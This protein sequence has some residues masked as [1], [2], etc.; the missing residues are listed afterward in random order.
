MSC[1]C[2]KF[3]FAGLIAAI[4]LS[5]VPSRAATPEEVDAAVLRGQTYLLSQ[6]K[7]GN[8][9][10]IPEPKLDPT[11]D[12]TWNNLQRWQWGGRTAAA[13]YGILASGV[14]SSDPRIAPTIE[15]LSNAH[16]QGFYAIS[17]R[18]QVWP[19]LPE[20][21]A[22]TA[23]ATDYKLLLNGMHPA[24]TKEGAKQ[25]FYPYF[26]MLPPASSKNAE[27]RAT[28]TRQPNWYDR[29][30]SQLCVL[31]MW[32]CEQAGQQVPPMYWRVVDEAWKKTQLPDGGWSYNHGSNVSTATMT[33][34]GVATLYIT[35]DYLLRNNRWE[36]CRG[37]V[38]DPF[39]DKG[40]AWIDQHIGEIVEAR[41]KYPFYAM[42]GLERI[43]VASGRKYFGTTDWY[44]VGAEYLVKNQQ[45][46]GSWGGEEELNGVP[47][48]VFAILYLVR[49][50]APVVMNKLEYQNSGKTAAGRLAQADPWNERP[51]DVANF[52]HWSGKQTEQYLN[53]QIVNLQV[54]SSELHDAPILYIAGSEA[55]ALSDDEVAKLRSFAEEGGLILGNADGG[56]D[57]FSRSF[58]ALGHKLFPKYEFRDLPSNHPI[59]VDEQYKASKWKTK[60]KIQGL[61]NGVRELM[62]L[63][64][65]SDVGRY[66]QTADEK[67]KSELFEL[68]QNILFYATDISNL[69]KRGDSYIVEMNPAAKV[70][71]TVQVAR[72]IV[73]DNPDPEPGGWR[74]LAAVL[75]NDDKIGISVNE[76][77]LGEGKLAGNK[78]AH[79]TGTTKFTLNDAQK[80]ELK[81]FVAA[82]GTLIVDAAG[83]SSAFEESADRELAAIFG[84]Q[85]SRFGTVLPATHEIYSVLNAKPQDKRGPLYR[86]FAVAKLGALNAPRVRGMEQGGRVRVFLSEEDLSA[87][88]VGEQV[89]GIVGYNP[90]SATDIMRGI[91]RYATGMKAP[92]PTTTAK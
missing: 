29:S 16:I 20:R 66:W 8:C 13:A 51:R 67:G 58:T 81:D 22:K 10:Y 33:A 9:E 69:R 87:G 19:F 82:G 34:A 6:I 32:S 37:G 65:K 78:I 46:G 90:T 70:S 73:G 23:S 57:S 59:F 17:M 61:S 44:K 15:W 3:A 85:A 42:Y 5:A 38:H 14:K 35:Q 54:P 41:V 11:D 63:I 89:D 7:N 12:S 74:R 53:W 56:N 86:K 48:T 2:R 50:R 43:G 62:L 72:L 77:K 27:S 28:G 21:E 39:I 47:D 52:A 24:D 4:V 80:K 26:T 18:A 76:V 30:V 49:G 55:L 91:V 64:P 75:N 84:G 40:L 25:G 31:G 1:S 88:L 60:P 92:A 79:L 83:G 71:P 36:I 45:P 68:G